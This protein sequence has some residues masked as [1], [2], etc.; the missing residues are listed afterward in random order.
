M[1]YL[2]TAGVVALLAY[3]SGMVSIKSAGCC[4]TKKQPALK[5]RS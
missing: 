4:D 1:C 5:K 2:H 3:F